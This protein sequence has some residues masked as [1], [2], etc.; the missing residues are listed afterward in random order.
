MKCLKIVLNL[1]VPFMLLAPPLLVQAQVSDDFS[2]GNFTLNPEW[3]GDTA[4][5]KVTNSSAIPPEMKPALQSDGIASDTSVLVTPS[6]LISNTEWQFWVKL[7]FN[8]SANNFARIYLVSDQQ[9]L[10][11]ELNGYFVQVGGEN[12]SIG[13]FRQTGL[14]AEQILNGTNAFTGNATNVFRIKVTRDELGNWSLF[15]DHE[16]GFAFQPEGSTNDLTFLS[17]NFFGIFCK[18]TSSNAQKFYFD[19]FYAGEIQIDT[20]PPEVNGISVMSVNSLDVAFS[21]DVDLNSSENETNYSVSSGIGNPLSASRDLADHSL[22]HLLFSQN[23]TS[24]LNYT[25]TVAGITD[26]A[27]NV[28]VGTGIPFIYLLPAPVDPFDILINEIMVDENPP[29]VGLPETD[30][31]EL[32]NRTESGINL[33]GFTLKPKESS[34]PLIFPSIM[35][36]AHGYLIVVKPSDV[37]SFE[38]YG[39]VIG[40]TSFSLNNEGIVVLRN[41]Q[42]KLIHSVSYTTTYYHDANKE[43]GGWSLE[44]I[45]PEHPCAGIDDWNASIDSTGGTPGKQNSVSGQ[46]SSSPEIVSVITLDSNNIEVN[47]SHTMDSLSLTKTSSYKVDNNVGFPAT[48][49]VED[50]SF[51]SVVLYFNDPFVI[52][53]LYQLTIDDTLY[54]CVHDFIELNSSYSFVLPAEAYPYD[55]LINEIMADPSPPV[56]LPEFEYIEIVNIT[57]S[58]LKMSGWTLKVGTTEKAVPNLVIAPGEYILFT[59]NEAVNL[60]SLVAHSIGFS[61]LGLSNTGTSISLLNQFGDLISFVSYSDNWYN[62]AAKAEGGWSLEQIDP[63][64]PCAGQDNWTVCL[65][66]QG[67]TPGKINSVQAENPLEPSIDKV[68]SIDDQTFEVYFNHVMDEQSISNASAYTVDHNVGNPVSVSPDGS[69]KTKAILNFGSIFLKGKTYTLTV[70][71]PISNCV[72]SYLQPGFSVSFGIPESAEK[73]D[74][75]I[76][77]VLFNPIGDGVDF[78][79]IFNRSAKIIDLKDLKLGTVQINDFEPNDTSYKY[80]SADNSLMFHNDYLV[81]TK[82]PTIVKEQYFTENPDGFL[83]VSSFPAYNNDMGTVILSTKSGIIIDAFTYS[84]SM[85]YPLLDVV[86]GV[87]LE[88]INPRRPSY[89]ETNWHS[90]SADCGFATPAYKNSQ[91]SEDIETKDEV[92][93]DPEIFSP[94]NDG[95]NDNLNIRYR[96]DSPGFTATITI[97]DSQGRLVKYLERNVLLGSMGVFSWDGRTEDNQKAAIGIYVIYF[98]AF[99]LN[100]RIKKYKKAAV[101]GGKL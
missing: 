39:D 37:T 92:T 71:F 64:N 97:Y 78:V 17:T 11:G 7:S 57:E 14:D 13:L 95:Y 61:S 8:T 41:P 62:D 81:L 66:E 100:G 51:N 48:V 1:L 6:T 80:V 38:S 85:H 65:D 36:G 89:D 70:D 52:N 77:E 15:S 33:Q 3:T 45:D 74:V 9:D 44:M 22:V 10:K 63:L 5:F 72:G 99:D 42:G 55:I 79:E 27:G 46:I 30:Y 34:D 96:F 25:L 35:I 69:V 59:E 23:F 16:G 31:L 98:E 32:F 28:M 86:E 26:P 84:E 76:N 93:V 58:Y 50:V 53:Q 12:D 94:D 49:K 4:D 101:L 67:G 87:S 91:F 21:E 54:D 2:D 47:F 56:G 75:V 68:I 18:Y 73:S 90:A 43:E 24:G 20:I 60:F 83:R 40:L 29:P 82:D 19:D 88:R